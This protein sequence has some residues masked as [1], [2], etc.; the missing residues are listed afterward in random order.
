MCGNFRGI[1]VM[2]TAGVV[3][4]LFGC[5]DWN[6]MLHKTDKTDIVQ[7][8]SSVLC[9]GTT[10]MSILP[11]LFQTIFIYRLGFGSGSGSLTVM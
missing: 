2:Y 3:C 1:A 11:F 5:V 8:R 10:Q 4:G 9:G 7:Y 6:W